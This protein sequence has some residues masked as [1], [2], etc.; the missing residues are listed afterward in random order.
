MLENFQLVAIVQQSSQTQLLRI[1]LQQALQDNLTTVWQIQY[2]TFLE[3]I[4]EIRFDPGYTPANQEVFF[5]T[6]FK[7]PD[8]LANQ[9]SLTVP[10]LDSIGRDDKVFDN[11]KGVV[12]FARNQNGEEQ[13]L[14]QRFTRTQVIQPG[15]FLLMQWDTYTGIDRPA[16]ML[17]RKLSAIYQSDE[18]KLLV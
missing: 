12:A 16:L 1:P 14:F 18:R 3:G 6:G 5:L 9:N 8:W 11:V 4:D 15:R 2:D 17:D 13:V 7:L 10:D